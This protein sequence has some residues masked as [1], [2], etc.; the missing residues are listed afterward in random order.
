[1]KRVLLDQGLSPAAARVL[2][3]EGWDAVHVMEVGLERAL[4]R[5]IPSNPQRIDSK[6]RKGIFQFRTVRLDG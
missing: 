2:R 5:V 4:R 3:S 6:Y 1:M